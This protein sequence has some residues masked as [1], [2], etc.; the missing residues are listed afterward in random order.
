MPEGL[1]RFQERLGY[2][3]TNT[4]LLTQALTHSSFPKESPGEMVEDYQRLEFLGDAVLELAVRDYLMRRFPQLPEGELSKRRSRVVSQPALKKAAYILELGDFVRLG[5]GEEMTRGRSKTSI[6]A[7][8]YEALLGAIYLDGGL[9]AAIQFLDNHF[10]PLLAD[11]I[12]KGQFV[13]HKTRLQELVQARFRRAPVYRLREE[14]G[15]QH[16]KVFEVEVL[17]GKRSAGR[18]RGRTKKEAEQ[19]AAEQAL[20]GLCLE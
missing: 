18:G 12:D 8:T 7:D 5:K 20:N 6:L 19:K 17:I 16:E 14:S 2:S 15:C 4:T 1:D 11:I 13:D 9:E 10:F 3:F